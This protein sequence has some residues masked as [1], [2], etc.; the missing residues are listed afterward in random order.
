MI[1]NARRIQRRH[2]A[3]G[4][5][6]FTLIELLIVIVVLGILAAIVVFALGGVTS[7]SAVAACTSDAKTVSV[8]VSAWEAQNSGIPTP[9]TYTA[10]GTI[11]A[12]GQSNLVP[13]YLKSWPMNESYYLIS[14]DKTTGDVTVALNTKDANATGVTGGTS[15]GVTTPKFTDLVPYE[16]SSIFTFPTTNKAVA[17]Q[18][19]CQGA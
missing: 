1:E 18:G 3:N 7:Q 4:E 19:I 14:F 6:G 17:G 8:A 10:T 12:T 5:D 15:S 13:T 2:Q 9:P 16:G 11:P